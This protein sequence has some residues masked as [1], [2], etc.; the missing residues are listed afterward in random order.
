MRAARLITELDGKNR[1]DHQESLFMTYR[2]HIKN[3][4]AVL[5]T[6]VS[7]PDGTPVRIEVVRQDAGFLASKSVEQLA[8]EQGIVPMGDFNQLAG[9]WP[10]EDSV[11]EFRAFIREARR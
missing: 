11:D 5:D 10:P 1:L 7:L 8:E 9:D 2:G 3:G 6:D 4:V